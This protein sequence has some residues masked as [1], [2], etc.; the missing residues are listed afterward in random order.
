[1]TTA[2][3]VQGLILTEG[4][5]PDTVLA[6]NGMIVGFVKEAKVAS[7]ENGGYIVVRGDAVPW[8][9]LES[10]GTLHY[11]CVADASRA[12]PYSIDPWV[13]HE[14]DVDFVGF[15]DEGHE[16]LT[17]RLEEIRAQRQR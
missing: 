5:D 14:G 11:M 9:N 16:V 3:D 12:S 15:A 13:K 6:F 2:I 17:Q 10:D 4:C 1:M 8:A 7:K